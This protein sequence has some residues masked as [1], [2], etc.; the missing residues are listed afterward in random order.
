MH[1]TPWNRGASMTQAQV[2]KFFTYEYRP[3]DG[4]NLLPG[5][6]GAWSLE[7][8]SHA[9]TIT[10]NYFIEGKVRR[11]APYNN[12]RIFMAPPRDGSWAA[13]F[14]VQLQSPGTWAGVAAGLSV[15]VPTVFKVFKRL[16]NRATGV[17]PDTDEGA[18][19][20]ERHQ[21][22][23]DAL[24]EAVEPALVRAHRVIESKS[25]TLTLSAGSVGFTFNTETKRYIESSIVDPAR[26][27]AVGNV[28]SYN[29]NGRTGRIFFDEL[30]RTVPFKIAK[31]A[32][33]Q[34]EVALARSLENYANKRFAN[35]DIRI[36]YIAR[37]A[38]D[39]SIKSILVIG[40]DF[41]FM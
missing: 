22:T 17:K 23:F 9:A 39:G 1:V 31:D 25:S 28:A 15:N 8:I 10:M 40:A 26:T 29:V 24:V 12:F 38:E 20:E 36:T 11:R 35:K 13:D 30:G 21:G 6:D 5:D 2:E 41:I 37:R 27:V 4:G 32:G 19:F 34:T 33:P 7:G 18:A 14:L 3:P 16:A